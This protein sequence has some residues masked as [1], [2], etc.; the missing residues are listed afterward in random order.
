MYYN[1]NYYYG[2]YNNLPRMNFSRVYPR[3]VVYN[4]NFAKVPNARRLIKALHDENGDSTGFW[5]RLL[6]NAVGGGLL[7]GTLGGFYLLPDYGALAGA[8]SGALAGV[9]GHIAN[10]LG[11]GRKE[12]KDK[13][14]LFRK[15]GFTPV[16][17]GNRLVGIELPKGMQDS[18]ETRMI[19]HDILD[20][21]DRQ[22]P[23][24]DNKNK[25]NIIGYANQ[26]DGLEGFDRVDGRNLIYKKEKPEQK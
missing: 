20:D 14:S 1:N 12:I 22:Y 4:R 2:G 9:G 15:H 25:D 3:V 23:L 26:M 11:H 24:Y 17:R 7:G 18:E 13:L 8:A 5:E 16:F 6:G 10:R 19:A 21:N